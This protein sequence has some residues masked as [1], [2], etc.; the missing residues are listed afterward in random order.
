[1]NFTGGAAIGALSRILVESAT[2]YAL[3]GRKIGDEA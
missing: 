1:V 2:A 3:A